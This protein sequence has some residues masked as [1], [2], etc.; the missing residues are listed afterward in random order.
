MPSR[1]GFSALFRN[2]LTRAGWIPLDERTTRR[3]SIADEMD[4]RPAASR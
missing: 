1:G 3:L 4:C 2:P